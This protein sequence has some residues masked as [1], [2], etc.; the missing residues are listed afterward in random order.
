MNSI[1]YRALSTGVFLFVVITLNAQYVVIPDSCFEKDK[2]NSRLTFNIESNRFEYISGLVA[3]YMYA[4][5]DTIKVN[6]DSLFLTGQL[7]F[8]DHEK[9]LGGA[10][11]MKGI[12]K[13]DSLVARVDLEDTYDKTDNGPKEGSFNI[14]MKVF[15]DD[16]L[17]FCMPDFYI[18]EYNI[19][20][21]F[22]RQKMPCK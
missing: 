13:G 5:F 18:V 1:F 15:P 2:K 21:L 4:K 14:K 11:I 19:S 10:G 3:M 6:G 8:Q 12:R 16:H 7:V 9:G 22:N 20:A 17:Y